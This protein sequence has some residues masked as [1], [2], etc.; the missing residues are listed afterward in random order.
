MGRLDGKVAIITGAGNGQG[1]AEAYIFA[2]E[3][4]KVIATD[5]QYENVKKLVDEIN[6]AFPKSAIALKHDV[7]LEED[8]HRVVQDGNDQFEQ[9]SILVNNAGIFATNSYIDV[10]ADYWN[11]ALSVNAWGQFVGIKTIIPSL[12]QAG[13]GSII[14][15]GSVASLINASGFTP[16][17]ASKG[18][19]EA[20]TRAAA[21][22]FGPDQIRV[23]SILPG[24]IDARI[25]KDSR[26]VEARQK[27]IY[28]IPMRR[29]GV[30]EDV[31]NLALFLASDESTYITGAAY[32]IDGGLSIQ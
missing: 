16:Y 24:A 31:A 9:I 3:G 23:N 12:K 21:S 13:G 8:W 2:K 6:Q 7:S 22:E 5:I 14:N 27:L 28:S 10:T 11:R 15:V 4:A 30:P 20:F 32:V 17:T 26:T 18:A 29:I 25:E 1:A 19:I